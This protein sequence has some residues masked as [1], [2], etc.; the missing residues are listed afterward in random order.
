MVPMIYLYIYVYKYQL[1]CDIL[2]TNDLS[3]CSRL[4]SH[5]VDSSTFSD[6]STKSVAVNIHMNVLIIII[7]RLCT[8]ENYAFLK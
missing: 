3:Q 2:N 7:V 6:W 1:D 5:N 8:G 4:Y